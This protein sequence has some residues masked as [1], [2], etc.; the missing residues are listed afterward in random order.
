MSKQEVADKTVAKSKKKAT[1]FYIILVTVA[2]ISAV[3]SYFYSKFPPPLTSSFFQML[4]QVMAT[5]LGFV[6]VVIFYYLG[7]FDDQKKNSINSIIQIKNE[8]RQHTKTIDYAMKDFKSTYGAPIKPKSTALQD[9][10]TNVFGSFTQLTLDEFEKI[11]NYVIHDVLGLLLSFAAGIVL[12]FLGLFY[13]DS[14]H[15][16]TGCW[17][18]LVAV[19]N[20]SIS[21]L[22]NF[23]MFWKDW[24]QTSDIMYRTYLRLLYQ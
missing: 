7:K 23:V 21:T 13:V 24:Q 15:N 4:I 18:L 20:S 10:V 2:I 19:I 9:Q 5:L 8:M 11:S 3:T 22:F 1:I 12:A 16:Q 14:L 17:P 6:L